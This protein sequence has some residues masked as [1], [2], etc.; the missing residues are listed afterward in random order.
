[1][2][3]NITYSATLKE[4]TARITWYEILCFLLII[5]ALVTRLIGLGDRVMSHDEVNHVVPSYSLYT[6]DGYRHDPI[7]HGPLQFHLIALSYFLFGDN[8]FTSRLP[9]AISSVAT[10]AFI[11]IYFKRY[12]GKNGAIMA[13]IFTLISPIMLFYGRYARNEAFIALEG[14][15]MAYSVLR[16]LEVHNPKYLF[17]L[18]ASLV[19]HF[20]TKETAY[21]YTAQLLIFSALLILLSLFKRSIQKPQDILKILITNL[22]VLAAVVM[23][24]GAA[25]FVLKQNYA[26]LALNADTTILSTQGQAIVSFAEIIPLLQPFLIPCLLLACAVGVLFASH[27]LLH[28]EKLRAIPG[29]D[30]L[31]LSGYLVLPLLTVFLVTFAGID[32]L[33][34]TVA[35][36]I[37]TNYVFL[38]FTFILAAVIGWIWDKHLWWKLALLFFC[39]YFVFFT[40]F[41][42]NG[43]GFFTGVIGSLGHW[44]AQQ[45]FARG[46]QPTYYYALLQIP[47]YEFLA[48]FG[49]LA[50]AGYALVNKQFSQT[51]ESVGDSVE[52]SDRSEEIELPRKTPV[53]FF[54][55]FWSITSLIAYSLAGEKMP[56]LTLHI[57]WPMLLASGWLVDKLINN[58]K[59]IHWKKIFESISLAS[60][61]IILLGILAFLVFGNNPPFAGKTQ[62][63]LVRTNHFL[64]MLAITA[65]IFFILRKRLHTFNR[66]AIKSISF[67]GLFLVLA[68]FTARTAYAAAFIN[69]DQA[70]EFLVYA[71]AARG[72]KDILEKI[73]DISI[74]TTRGLDIA[75]AYDNHSLYPF[76]WYLRHYPNRVG[77]M[78]NPTRSLEN[79]PVILVG[80]WNYD[81]VEPIVRNNYFAIEYNRLWWPMEDYKNLTL[82]RVKFAVTNPEM[83]QAIFNIWLNRDYKLYSAITNNK[84][85]TPSTW[86]PAERM[87]MYIRKDIAAQ[88]WELGPLTS[89]DISIPLDPYLAG[90]TS[91]QPDL[92]IGTQGSEDG[93][94]NKPRGLAVAPDGS[95][96]IADTE[97]HRIQHFS[98]NGTWLASWGSFADITL[99]AAP[100]GTFNQPWDVAIAPDGSVFVADTW[101]Y[102]I[103]KFSAEGT[104]IKMWGYS[105]QGTT[106][107]GFWGP[108]GIAIDAAGKVYVTDTGNKRVVI[109]DTDGNYITQFGSAGIQPGQFDEPVGI[110][111]DQNGIVYVAD[112]WNRRV[113]TFTPDGSGLLYTPSTYWDVDAWFGQSLNN[114]PFITVDSTGNV[115]ISDPE[116]GRILEFTSLGK[117]IQGWTDFSGISDIISQPNGIVFDQQGALWMIDSALHA[118]MRFSIME[119]KDIS[120]VNP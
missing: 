115:Y 118:L 41:F 14:L 62:V 73:E 1:M 16:Y 36:P 3:K 106:P 75:V 102:R 43:L 18:T 30:I 5:L 6:G 22:V 105:A 98:S 68:L 94:F 108:R 11:L 48:A 87:K 95:L 58:L 39:F 44:L 61:L 114:K 32:P 42:T 116:S 93:Q 117:F 55:F 81:K 107:D 72:P 64:F 25:V 119:T 27:N 35:F 96:Y 89:A 110:E 56:Q 54:L 13:G 88:M 74:R 92:T 113:Q 8:D 100:E 40:T 21:I 104:F 60:A 112:T 50:A 10:I 101:N 84:S 26:A 59:G 53:M 38:V 69:Y 33:A 2:K 79:S 20:T 109:F 66:L 71:H 80:M 57:T 120:P 37:L 97:N 47:V 78:E 4:L 67:L 91:K 34:Y 52:A 83:R 63:Q 7:T 23:F 82:D 31:I 19:L 46:G 103:Q 77:Y 28:W 51:S 49:L 85:L 90:I 24:T 29:F 9:H 17:F 76:W 65:G 12:L 111:V 45:G 70:T 86:S 99:G 15:I